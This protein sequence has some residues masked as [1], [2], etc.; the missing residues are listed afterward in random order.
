MLTI[1]LAPVSDGTLL[2]WQQMFDDAQTAQA[3]SRL[4]G[5]ANE[6]NLDRLTHVL[7]KANHSDS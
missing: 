2:T 7:S 6:Q 4:V 3:I 1:E 5:D